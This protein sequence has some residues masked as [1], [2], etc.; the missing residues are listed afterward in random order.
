MHVRVDGPYS[1]FE[2]QLA[3]WFQLNGNNI[4]YEIEFDYYEHYCNITVHDE[5]IA[6]IFRL[7]FDAQ[8]GIRISFL[9]N[10]V[11]QMAAEIT[12]EIDNEI[13]Q[14]LQKIAVGHQLVVERTHGPKPR[15]KW[16]KT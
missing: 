12:T 4:P 11:D 13:V 16:P 6:A 15:K 8:L 5:Q 14:E 3:S 7:A 1:E 10:L 2:E 9:Q